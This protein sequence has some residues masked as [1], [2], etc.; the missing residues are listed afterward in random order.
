MLIMSPLIA[1]NVLRVLHFGFCFSCFN[2]SFFCISSAKSVT[3]VSSFKW[4]LAGFSHID[5]L[6]GCF[7]LLVPVAQNV[8]GKTWM[9]FPTWWSLPSVLRHRDRLLWKP[10]LF[11]SIVFKMLHKMRVACD[12]WTS[13]VCLLWSA[14]DGCKILW[15]EWILKNSSVGR[16]SKWGLLLLY[17]TILKIKGCTWKSLILLCPL[18]NSAGIFFFFFVKIIWTTQLH[19]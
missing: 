18:P 3:L 10:G 9:A 13:T 14:S 17:N 2:F 11:K 5:F 12:L 1:V 7:H 4:S 6:E 15:E 16:A 8:S 19:S